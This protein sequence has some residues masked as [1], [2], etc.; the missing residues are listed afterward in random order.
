MERPP[1]TPSLYAIFLYMAL[2]LAVTL[3]TAG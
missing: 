3:C 1:R 2:G